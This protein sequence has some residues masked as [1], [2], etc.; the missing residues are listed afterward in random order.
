[1]RLQQLKGLCFA[2]LCH[3]ALVGVTAVE[4]A[5]NGLTSRDTPFSPFPRDGPF[6]VSWAAGGVVEVQLVDE[7]SAFAASKDGG[8]QMPP[9][10]ARCPPVAWTSMIA[11]NA[12]LLAL[13]TTVTAQFVSDA[14]YTFRVRLLQSESAD[15]SAGW[16][17]P[18]RF[19]VAPDETAWAGAGWIGGGS[20]L[21]TDWRLRSASPIVRARAYA[22]GL[23]AFELF[24]NGEKVGDHMMDAGQAVWDEKV[25]P[26][27]THPLPPHP[28]RHAD[29]IRPYCFHSICI[30]PI[31]V[32]TLYH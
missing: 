16:S 24:V 25:P 7:W 23:G 28:F 8:D 21:R 12:T 26:T 20:E 13:P 29:P 3:H 4:L 6:V 2:T 22:S 19:D 31:V 15:L 32:Y 14:S 5:I 18:M 11:Q 1:M 10:P 30:S 27:H 17:S 9:R